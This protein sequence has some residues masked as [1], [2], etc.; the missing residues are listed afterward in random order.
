MDNKTA[1]PL[2]NSAKVWTTIIV[3]ELKQGSSTSPLTSAD[4]CLSADANFSP[5]CA[6]TCPQRTMKA[7]WVLILGLQT[8]FRV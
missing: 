2:T 3:W 4:M 8:N 7:L 1:K 5:C 6:Y